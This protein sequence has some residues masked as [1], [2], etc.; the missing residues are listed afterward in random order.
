MQSLREMSALMESASKSL[1]NDQ[2]MDASASMEELAQRLDEMQK[3]AS[4]LKDLE[5]TLGDIAQSKSAM[6]CQRLA[7]VQDVHSVVGVRCLRVRW[8]AD[9][10][11]GLEL[12]VEMDLGRAAVLVIDPRRVGNKYLPNSSSG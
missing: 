5:S 1:D 4:E 11:T 12:H 7:P 9:K 3:E 6:R 10:L 8:P 2:L